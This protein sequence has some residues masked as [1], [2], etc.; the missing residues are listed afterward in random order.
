MALRG[1]PINRAASVTSQAIAWLLQ[2]RT[3]EGTQEW[4]S[5]RSLI[6]VVAYAKLAAERGAT[7]FESEL[8]EELAAT[9]KTLLSSRRYTLLVY[10]LP[11]LRLVADEV[12]DPD[13]DF[14]RAVDTEIKELVDRWN[15]EHLEVDPRDPGVLE[16]VL[17][18]L[19]AQEEQGTRE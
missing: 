5:A 1:L 12:R 14:Q 2:L 17:G 15:V 10:V 4:V 11:R 7:G 18:E 16:I 13:P 3:E 6:D 8:F 19:A 9:T